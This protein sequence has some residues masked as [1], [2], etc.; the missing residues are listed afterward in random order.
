MLQESCKIV[1]DSSVKAAGTALIPLSI[2]R[3]PALTKITASMAKRIVTL[4]G[5]QS[6]SGLTSFFSIVL[7][8]ATGVRIANEVLA[9]VPMLG[10][11][12]A[13]ISTACLHLFTGGV[14]IGVCELIK[15]GNLSDSELQDTK[16]C[17]V[18]CSRLIENASNIVF[19]TIRGLNPLESAYV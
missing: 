8:A 14:L 10:T 5:Y 6:L 7:G 1:I 2:V 3:V 18:F 15:A 17:K 19:R 13:C 12:A 4:Y 11:G 16:F 9:H